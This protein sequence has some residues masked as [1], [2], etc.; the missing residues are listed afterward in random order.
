MSERNQDFNYLWDGSNLETETKEIVQLLENL[1]LSA[2]EKKNLL[3]KILIVEK[4]L[5]PYED[6]DAYSVLLYQDMK[7]FFKKRLENFKKN[8]TIKENSK[9]IDVCIEGWRFRLTTD[10][11][12]SSVDWAQEAGISS[13][14]IRNFLDITRKLGGHMFWPTQIKPP[15]DKL[16]DGKDGTINTCRG[17]EK[18]FYD[19]IDLTLFYLKEWYLNHEK[20]GGR[21]HNVFQKYA[22]W[23]KLFEDEDKEKSF[24]KFIDFF[25]LNDFVDETYQIRN[26]CYDDSEEE[27]LNA[28]SRIYI[29]KTQ[30]GYRKYI[31]N[32]NKCIE[33]RNKKMWEIISET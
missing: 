6:P 3:K 21:L 7:C 9:Y 22:A 15:L 33:E 5:Y 25:C 23:L 31:K 8:G 32:T 16:I 30:E 2:D 28:E 11:I 19:R 17:G 10:Y 29:P 20:G 4:R 14:E 18:G 1:S 12:G 27:F 26:L 24:Q 13:S